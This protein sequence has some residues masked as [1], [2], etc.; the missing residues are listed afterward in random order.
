MVIAKGLITHPVTFATCSRG[1]STFCTMKN[2]FIE[3]EFERFTG[4]RV[5]GRYLQKNSHRVGIESLWGNRTEIMSLLFPS[6]DN[7]PLSVSFSNTTETLVEE[8]AGKC[9]DLLQQ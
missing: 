6:I 3:L 8:C 4:A 1:S 9:H 2:Q 5:L 7:N